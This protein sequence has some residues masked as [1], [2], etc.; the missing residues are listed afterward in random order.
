VVNS[1]TFAVPLKTVGQHLSRPK[2]QHGWLAD[3]MPKRGKLTRG[4][5]F[6]RWRVYFRGADGREHS[7]KAEKIIDRD[8]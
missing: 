2:S 8:L 1:F 6:G 7:K 4:R 5:F 3:R